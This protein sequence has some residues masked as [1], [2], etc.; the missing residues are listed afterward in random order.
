MTFPGTTLRPTGSTSGRPTVATAPSIA[1]GGLAVPEHE[2]RGRPGASSRTC[3]GAEPECDGRPTTVG[4]AAIIADDP[5]AAP[6]GCRTLEDGPCWTCAW[7]T[8]PAALPA[9]TNA[10]CRRTT[11][12]SAERDDADVRRCG[13]STLDRLEA[14]P[15]PER[16][17]ELPPA[18]AESR[19]SRPD[20]GGDGA[21][22]ATGRRVPAPS[23]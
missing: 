11:F 19:W 7:T 18:G 2:L 1:E 16:S 15:D 6:S 22:R 17:I 9:A 20:L 8:R 3:S 21:C 23:I 4:L 5:V 13:P 10:R 14:G 12:L